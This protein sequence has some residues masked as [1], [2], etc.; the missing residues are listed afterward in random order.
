[1]ELDETD[2]KILQVLQ[3]DARLSLRQIAKKV[4][5]SVA[6]VMY[7][8]RGLE[9]D[10]IIQKYT[11]KLDEEKLGYDVQVVIEARISKGK[12]FEV[13]RKIAIHPNVFAVYDVTGDFDTVII[14]KFKTRR[15]MDKFLKKIQTFPFV[16][17]TQTK[18][19]L[20]VIKEEGIKP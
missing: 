14:A 20:N 3:Q 15:A 17:R 2:K 19:I 6:T 4:G 12:L 10:R 11:T 18:L 9:E 5:V 1:M 7:R 13:E 16:E 8:L